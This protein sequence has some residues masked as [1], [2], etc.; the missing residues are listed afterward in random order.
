MSNVRIS[1]WLAAGL[2]LTLVAC[3]G[4][5]D[6]TLDDGP[7]SSSDVDPPVAS[8]SSALRAW[9]GRAWNGRAWNG[10]AW[11]GRAWNGS[12]FG[13]DGVD[14]RGWRVE[15]RGYVL[16]TAARMSL[17]ASR[18][19]FDGYDVSSFSQ[20]LWLSS[21]AAPGVR[22][23]IDGP[24]SL[25]TAQ[26]LPRGVDSYHVYVEADGVLEPM[27][28]DANGASVAAIPLRGEWNT[29]EAALGTPQ[30]GAW[31]DDGRITFAA[32][33]F[34]LAKCVEMGYRPWGLTPPDLHRACVRMLRA[35]Y[36]GDGRSWTADGT[37]VNVYD[38]SGVQVR[39][40]AAPYPND[41]TWQWAFEAEW[42]EAGAVC[43]DG[44]RVQNLAGDVPQCI[45]GRVL[46]VLSTRT[47]GRVTPRSFGAFGTAR[48]MTEFA[49]RS[50]TQAAGTLDTLSAARVGA[51]LLP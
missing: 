32:R 13:A 11:N 42:T 2:S 40:R 24:F 38:A 39:E 37:L 6:E 7:P 43:V 25:T 1:R 27:F 21:P 9:N 20:Q 8:T 19:V 46:D 41:A 17:A 10:R 15:A 14:G 18:L 35:D 34:A 30:G 28:P 22:F 33:G 3:G 49:H 29:D 50:T 36:C 48:L 5:A 12:S 16:F 47:C 23:R 45:T 51:S 31:R 4:P 44:F 26:G